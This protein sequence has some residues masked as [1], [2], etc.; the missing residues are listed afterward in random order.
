MR[1]ILVIAALV[2]LFLS[3][4]GGC[5]GDTP[6]TADNGQTQETPEAIVTIKIGNITDLTGAGASGMELVNVA[7]EDMASYYNDNNLI[8]GVQFEVL[9]WDSQL[10][11]NKTI[12]GYEWLRH[13]NVDFLVTCVPVVASTLRPRLE[14][15]E[16]ALFTHSGELGTVE[17]P[18]YVFSMQSI[19]QHDAYT[20]LNWIAE[21][22]W[23]Y[24]NNGPAKI[25]GAAWAEPYASA[26]FQATEE[27]ARAHPDQ[28]KYKGGYLTDF[29]FSWDSEIDVLKECDYIYPPIIMHEFA[30]DLRNVGSEA[31]LIGGNAHT[32]FF[33]QV[34]DA[35][36]WPAIDGMLFVFGG[37]WW[38]EPL[39]EVEF[40]KMILN[41]YHPGKEEEIT[42]RSGY[43]AMTSLR[44]LFD[45]IEK[46]VEDTGPQGFDSVALNETA[47]SWSYSWDYRP[48]G[49]SFTQ[50]KR[51]MP[52]DLC[53]QEASAEIETL[54]RKD[55]NW[56]PI[57]TKP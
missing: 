54:S 20:F 34:S 14:A 38:T 6:S 7:L 24:A 41:T 26:F 37:A 33:E 31:K 56:Y 28:F 49:Y 3:L 1:V 2:G 48:R 12:P 18:G 15:D 19:P 50:T 57:L 16:M 32:A 44:M 47:Q 45:I 9:H 22:D 42:G 4:L 55:P 29:K 51:Y 40:N 21:N 11:P 36:A 25:G 35:K 10:D 8:P 46:T 27:Y 43:G 53:I 5:G 13:R 52:N 30:K 39:E 23:D 17:P